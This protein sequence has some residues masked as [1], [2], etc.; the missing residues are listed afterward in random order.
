MAS[1]ADA[2]V[3]GGGVGAGVDLGAISIRALTALTTFV[4]GL[5]PAAAL[6]VGLS[7][8]PMDT[9]TGRWVSV[10]GP[11]NISIFRSPTVPG[12]GFRY[13]TA[14]GVREDINV[15]PGPTGEFRDPKTGRVFARLVRIGSAVGILV[16]TATLVRSRAQQLCPNP[17]EE[18]HGPRGREY[19]DYVK[20]HFNPGN[21]TPSGF[22]YEFP[23]RRNA[24]SVSFDDCQRRTG[25]L[26]EYKGPG[27]E[28]SLLRND[29]AWWGK[30][31]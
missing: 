5:A 24:N 14:D 20:M 21:P 11:G 19:E 28:K 2:P 31:S 18:H 15:A 7:L 6:G 25:D 8:I 22:G 26:A 17:E 16:S 27:F 4:V 23:K 29:E 12:V 10:A 30:E 1:L 13:T 9:P 3:V